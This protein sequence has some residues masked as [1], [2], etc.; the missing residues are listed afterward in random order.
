MR[1]LRRLVVATLL[2]AIGCG[3][4]GG[5]GGGIDAG[6]DNRLAIVGHTDLGARGM[7][8]ALAVAGDTVYVGSRIDLRPIL[9]VDVADP[10]HPAVVGEIGPPEE[11]LMGISSREL[12]AIPE[13]NLLIVMNSACSLGLHGCTMPNAEPE[14]LKFFDITDRRAPVFL[15]RYDVF[16]TVI[17]RPR[18]PHEFY[19]HRDGDRVLIYLSTPPGPPG[20]EI[21]DVTDPRTPTR[22]V[23]WDPN[24]DGL[25]RLT[26]DSIMHSVGV[27]ADGRTAYLSHQQAGL[28]LADVATLEDISLI[29]PPAN[30]LKWPPIESMGPHS[31]VPLPG[32][33]VLIVTEEIYPMPFGIGCPWGHLRTVD[34]A[35]PAAPV[36]AGEFKLTEND[37]ASCGAPPE[38]TTFTAH[39]VTTTHDVALVTWYSGGLQAVDVSDPARP[40]RLAELRPEPIASVTTEDPALGGNPVAMW[41][42]PVIQDGLIYVVD[43]RNGLYIV[44][45]TGRWEE[46][47]AGVA[48]AEG[49]SNRRTGTK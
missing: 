36:I 39:N 35:N 15:A 18:S 28:L 48:F 3:D 37:P 47:I 40:T 38:R 27:S 30:A 8:S 24:Q 43:I 2:A 10:A 21:I 16:G 17:T 41:S 19:V 22:V 44:R 45:Y 42:Y 1:T 26:S 34:I 33:D 31:A 32:R 23:T 13:L 7:N 5:G 25:M 4:D 20:L 12:R 49:N 14:N 11:G 46:Q 29:T 9:I 6:P